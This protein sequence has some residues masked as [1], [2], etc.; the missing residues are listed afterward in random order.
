MVQ[1]PLP[2]GLQALFEVTATLVWSW[3]SQLSH[4]TRPCASAWP[5]IEGLRLWPCSLDSPTSRCAAIDRVSS[6]F[7]LRTLLLEVERALCRVACAP[8]EN[9][10]SWPPGEEGGLGATQASGSGV[11]PWWIIRIDSAKSNQPVGISFLPRPPRPALLK[12][13]VMGVRTDGGRKTGPGLGGEGRGRCCKAFILP[14][15]VK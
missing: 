2:G 12:L 9:L 13:P 11:H 8:G 4:D 10:L 3:H 15:W 6:R 14:A 1:P 7:L 5:G